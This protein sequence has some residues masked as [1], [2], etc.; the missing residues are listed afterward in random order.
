MGTGVLGRMLDKL[1]D[2]N[3]AVSAIAIDSH[4]VILDGDSSLNRPVDVIPRGGIS[5]FYASHSTP[6]STISQETMKDTFKTLNG[7]V[8]PN[9]GKYADL[10]SQYFIDG[11]EKATTIRNAISTITLNYSNLFDG[12]SLGEQL[13]MVSKLIIA[14]EG[15]KINRDAFY[16]RHG[17]F[18]HH[19]TMKDLLDPQFTQIN[20]ALNAFKTEMTSRGLMDQ[21]TLVLTSE[22]GRTLSANGGQGM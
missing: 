22:F 19:S 16:V 20:N 2:N 9:S 3:Y 6:S 5:E 21:I 4:G 14:R 18:D 11:V 7:A 1:Q 12:T 13:K 8:H 15:R 17:G 10:W